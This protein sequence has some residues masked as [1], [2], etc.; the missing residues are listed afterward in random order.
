MHA[1]EIGRLPRSGG[2]DILQPLL[3]MCASALIDYCWGNLF[4]EV[5]LDLGNHRGYAIIHGKIFWC[6]VKILYMLFGYSVAICGKFL[7]AVWALFLGKD[8]WKLQEKIF[9]SQ[10]SKHRKIGNPLVNLFYLFE[11]ENMWKRN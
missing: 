5:K 8:L 9:T 10:F 11:K 1:I 4:T 6:S 7:V 2:E 3:N